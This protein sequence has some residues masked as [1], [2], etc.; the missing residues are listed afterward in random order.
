MP[1]PAG[2]EGCEGTP[3]IVEPAKEFWGLPMNNNDQELV[4]VPLSDAPPL[5]DA[6]PLSNVAPHKQN[7]KL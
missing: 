6:V 5:P 3:L 2:E 4:V 1:I 7:K